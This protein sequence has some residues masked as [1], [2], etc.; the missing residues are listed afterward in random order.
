MMH[1]IHVVYHIVKSSMVEN[2]DEWLVICQF[3]PY[4]PLSLSLNVS[5]MKPTIN[6]SKCFTVKCLRYT[7]RTYVAM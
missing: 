1:V 7:V 4:K 5:L 6:S 3:F 2:F